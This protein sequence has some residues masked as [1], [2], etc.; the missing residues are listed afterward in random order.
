M[1]AAFT[2]MTS[3]VASDIFSLVMAKVSGEL[4]DCCEVGEYSQQSTWL[5]KAFMLERC[6]CV[7]VR[8][9]TLMLK[10]LQYYARP[11]APL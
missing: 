9:M 2:I 8:A 7:A 3:L 4:V 11:I 6:N 1:Q 10:N 5:E